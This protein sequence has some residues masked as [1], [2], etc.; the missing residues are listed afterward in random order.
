MTETLLARDAALHAALPPAL[1]HPRHRPS[2][3]VPHVMLHQGGHVP[4]PERMI[5]RLASLWAGPIAGTADR[6][7]PVRSPPPAVLWRTALCDVAPELS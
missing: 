1:W 5:A 3:W 2:A 4:L 7:E 6:V